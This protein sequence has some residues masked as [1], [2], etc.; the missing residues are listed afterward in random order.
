M[1]ST[2]WN[3]NWICSIYD[4]GIVKNTRTAA[5]NQLIRSALEYGRNVY[6]FG[7]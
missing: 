7:P 2:P 3:E 4:L 1:S 5:K 6:L